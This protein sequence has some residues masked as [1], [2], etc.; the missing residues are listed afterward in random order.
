M[1]RDEF[2][3][4]LEAGFIL[5]DRSTR[6]DYGWD[7]YQSRELA[8]HPILDLADSYIT[9]IQHVI[10]Q[11]FKRGYRVID[12]RKLE[13][14]ET[15]GSALKLTDPAVG[16][17]RSFL[18]ENLPE[19]LFECFISGGELEAENFRAGSGFDPSQPRDERGQWTSGG[20]SAE[21]Q[22]SQEMMKVEFTEGNR[23]SNIVQ[24]INAGPSTEDEVRKRIDL[25]TRGNTTAEGVRFQRAV[26]T[27]FQLKE[28]ATNHLLKITDTNTA[29]FEFDRRFVRAEYDETQQWFKDRNISELTVYRGMLT[30]L[31]PGTGD[32][33]IT[34][35]PASS[36]T[37]T[38]S[39][40]YSFAQAS[41]EGAVVAMKVPVSKI[42]S[43]GITGQGSV[44]EG[45]I[46]V[47]G[48]PYRV[49]LR[50]DAKY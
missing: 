20:V 41:R 48:G 50:P 2:I 17:V 14:A 18:E 34:M 11:A 39:T 4:A 10:E 40:A 26:E 37:I 36:W 21:R 38:R 16:E 43:M 8:Q 45:E 24:R 6:P 27:E 47:L 12:R 25:W 1:I 19:I 33:D 44:Y 32:L 35:Q 31:P 29:D 49:R 13:G 5:D 23:V 7:T 15:I 9:K 28:T 30:G 3:Q 42:L 22:V 46:V